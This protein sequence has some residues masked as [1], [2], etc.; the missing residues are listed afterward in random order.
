[1]T[2][3]CRGLGSM[4][5]VG[6][7]VPAVH[8]PGPKAGSIA[9]AALCCTMAL[10]FPLLAACW[11]PAHAAEGLR[12]ITSEATG[13]GASRQAWAAAA[14]LSRGIN[15]SVYA[16]PR[17]GDWGLHMDPRWVD[18]LAKAGFRSVR[19]QV[20]WSNHAGTGLD[21]V[22]DES[23]AR[24]IDALIDTLLARGMTVVLNTCFYSQFDGSPPEEGEEPVAPEAVRPRFIALWR[25][26]AQRH[27]RRSERLLF[28]LYNAPR[29]DAQAWNALAAQAVATIRQSNPTRV[30]V[31]SPIAS[32]AASLPQL[33]LPR[34]RHLIVSFH[35]REPREFTNQG[36]PWYPGAD[37]W[38]G[39]PC[40]N[41]QQQQAMVHNLDL[42]KAWSDAQGYPVWLGSFGAASTAPMDSRARYLRAVRDAAEARGIAWTHVD[43][44]ANFNLREPPLDSGLYDVVKRRWHEP[45]REAL[46]GP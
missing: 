24:R 25:Q 32:G 16:A 14:A 38:L 41:A 40:C 13:Q 4:S 35:S 19:L 43:F 37:R 8:A 42:A 3:R 46:L 20:R 34:D 45:L 33:V 12:K 30:I 29:G 9:K 18:T 27:A 44:A 17:E 21:A 7:S 15:L 5:C 22:L 23:F 26:L 36:L 1:M 11:T 28:E 6:S 39:T 10:L 2:P 31:L